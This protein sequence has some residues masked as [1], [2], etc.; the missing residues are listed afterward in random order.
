MSAVQTAPDSTGLSASIP[1]RSERV[2]SEPALRAPGPVVTAGVW[3]LAPGQDVQAFADAI[4]ASRTADATRLRQIQA[5]T[6][7]PL[8]RRF[9][10]WQLA[11]TMPDAL[12]WPE[13]DLAQSELGDWPRRD[14]RE[15][16]A[17]RL[18]D[19]S[20]LPASQ[21]IAW[22]GARPPSTLEG[23]ASLADALRATGKTDAAAATLRAAW[24]SLPGDAPLQQMILTRFPNLLTSDDDAAR[25]DV[26]L[27]GS[28]ETAA[29]ALLPLISPE[30]AAVVRARLALRH[31]DPDAQVLIAALPPADQSDPGLIYERLLKLSEAG[32]TQGEL[33]LVGYLAPVLPSEPA[34]E[35]LW[36]H[37]RL[38]VEALEAGNA[39]EAYIAASHSGLKSGAPAAEA[40]FYAGWIALTRLN[41]PQEADRRF[42]L[43]EQMSNSPITQARALYWRGRAADAEGDPVG[44][45]LFYAQAARFPTTFY[46]QMG[47]A[48][49]GF[50]S[51][52]I[53][54]DPQITPKDREVF[55]ARDPVRVAHV[56]ASLGER[57]LWRT[58]VVSLSET[59]PDTVSEAQLVDIAQAEGEP[60][61]AM[62]V[63]RN[64]AKRGMIL[65]DRGYPVRSA[66]S[67]V[68]DAPETALVLSV[69]RQESSFNPSAR[70]GAGALGMMQLLPSTARSVA[71]REG[72]GWGRLEDPDFNMRVG[73]AYLGQL[74]NTF[75]GSY[76]LAAAAYNA[77]PGRPAQ[78][79]SLCG[80]PR[81]ANDDPL[82]FIE[83]IPFSE[84]R[85]YVMRVLEG[86]EVY[87]ARL[88]GGSAPLELA[89]DLRRGGYGAT[90]MSQTGVGSTITTDG[91]STDAA[92]H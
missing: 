70:S 38:V 65:P 67:G 11:D 35:K 48:R 27:Y 61:L 86:T 25:V 57:D 64:G 56:L 78:W 34:A 66:P 51:L 6:A 29:E 92:T 54:G 76:L 77:G 5:A 82:D 89:A 9:A 24:R 69:T 84:T 36:R 2:P 59:L 43:L 80:D 39:R 44:A 26:L 10:L 32:D 75:S 62:R 33:A 30:R 42:H 79:T 18:L 58:F 60:S 88:N 73:A 90:S 16:A 12:T 74:V 28:D 72:L 17:E 3:S 31:N 47:A 87:R 8:A 40:E 19:R 21:V 13:A 7:D 20:G 1:I 37:G 4:R 15:K 81:N 63:V 53:G 14:R 52:N 85:D 68:T 71:R 49:A 23:A 55:E 41:D 46:G 22:F 50:T 45:Q 83:C 91:L